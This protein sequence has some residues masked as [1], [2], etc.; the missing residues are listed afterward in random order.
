[1]IPVTTAMSMATMPERKEVLSSSLLMRYWRLS[2]TDLSMP[3]R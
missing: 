2:V 3:Q 1:M